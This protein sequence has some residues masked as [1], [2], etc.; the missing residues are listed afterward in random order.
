[1]FFVFFF[2]IVLLFST[3]HNISCTNL[4][5]ILVGTKMVNMIIINS[6]F[7]YGDEYRGNLLYNQMLFQVWSEKSIDVCHRNDCEFDLV[8]FI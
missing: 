2:Q 7:V 1:M 3:L 8:T 5:L 6:T 4:H